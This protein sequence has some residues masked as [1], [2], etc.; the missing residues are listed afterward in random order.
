VQKLEK[1]DGNPVFAALARFELAL[2]LWPGARSRDRAR[3][4]ATQAEQALA[5]LGEAE[6]KE[7]LRVRAWLS[8]VAVR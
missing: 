2:V 7:L 4:L 1:H 8:K 5:G 3:A 6:A